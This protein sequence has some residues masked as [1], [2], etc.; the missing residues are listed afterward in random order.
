MNK[1]HRNGINFLGLYDLLRGVFCRRNIFIFTVLL[2]SCTKEVSVTPPDGV[3]AMIVVEG[4]IQNDEYA[5]V[6]LSR[7]SGYF[8]PIPSFTDTLKIL[9]YILNDLVVQNATVIV[10]DGLTSD[11][12]KPELNF[13]SYSKKYKL[14]YVYMG[15]V[16]KGIPGKSYSLTVIAD[17]KT[18][19]SSTKIPELINLDTLYWKADI[20]DQTV[21]FPWSRFRDPDSLG[22]AYRLFTRRGGTDDEYT[23]ALGSEF[24]DYFINATEFDFPFNRGEQISDDTLK[25]TERSRIYGKYAAGDKMDV[26]FCTIDKAHFDFWRTFSI[27]QQSGGSP[28]AAPINLKSNI[29]G[30]GVT[31]IWGGY[32]ATFITAEAK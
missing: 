28:F 9:D 16:L 23:A 4:W 5:V 11:T 27:S 26:K 14:P 29:V 13:I 1:Q 7:S 32:G 25:K 6:K 15:K 8:D 30:D 18:F 2:V 21:G 24:D 3:P 20:K 31:G 22:N 10:S 12:L 19:T 17:G